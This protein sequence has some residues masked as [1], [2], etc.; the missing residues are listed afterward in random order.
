MAGFF[1]KVASA[2][3][4]I[5]ESPTQ[6]PPRASKDLDLD[7]IGSDASALLAQLESPKG[8]ARATGAALGGTGAV[9]SRA[10]SQTGSPGV[11]PTSRAMPEFSAPPAVA[12][13]VQGSAASSM[14]ADDIFLAAGVADTPNSAIRILRM[15]AGLSMFPPEQQRVMLR[16]MDQADPTWSEEEMLM[17]AHQRLAALRQHLE[18]LEGERQASL[19]S[20]EESISK[21]KASGDSMVAEI[22]AQIAE[23]QKLRNDALAETATAV[24]G[25]EG[26]KREA[27]TVAAEARARLDGI[28]QSLEGLV[29]FL[30]GGAPGPQGSSLGPRR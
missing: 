16:A 13:P 2:F 14:T 8:T 7:S 5:E 30:S 20:L 22:D 25:L 10:P 19:T 15:L 17:D 26:Q 6:T 27:D 28:R 29:S 11:A 3:V 24:S 18:R 12:T 21:A 4:V 9:S 23:L 1:K